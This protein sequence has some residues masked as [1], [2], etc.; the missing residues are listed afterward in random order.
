MKPKLETYQARLK[1]IP[2]QAL[3]DV[4]INNRRMVSNVQK[5][6]LSNG[7]TV[8]TREVHSAP[9]VTV[10][11]W[12]NVGSSQDSLG[13]SGIAHQLEH[14]MFKG[15][16]KRPIQFSKIFNRLGSNSNAFTSY[17]QTAYY[18][19]VYKNQLQALLELE[20]DRMANLLIDSQDLAR[21]KQ[22]VIS[23]LEGYENSPKYRLKRAVMR[24]IFPHHGYGLPTGGTKKDVQNL[25]VEQIRE[26]YEK[27]YHP[28]H[29]ILVIVGDFTT[30]KTLQT[31]KEIFGKIPPSQQS[32]SFPPSPVFQSSS[33]PIIL[34]EPGGRKL[35][36]VIYPLP[37]LHHPDIPA[38]GVMDYILTGGKNS[39]L[40]QTLVSSG[41]VTDLSARVVSLRQGGW[42]DLSVIPAPGQD[43]QTVYSTIESAI[44][45][46][47]QTGI[48]N[49]DIERA[50]RQITA[51]VIFNRQDITSQAMQ[52]ANDQLIANDYE[53]TEKYLEGVSRVN[54]TQVIEITKKYLTKSAVIGF[55][56]PDQNTSNS[57]YQTPGVKTEEFLEQVPLEHLNS[58]EQ[59]VSD[60]EVIKY[61]PS[62]NNS[63][64]PIVGAI[65]P[66]KLKLNNGLK[67]LL[68][69]DR[70]TPTITVA[71]YIQGGKE[72]DQAQKAGLA[73]LVADSLMNG[74]A[75]Q[76]MAAIAETLDS[77]GASLDFTAFREGVRLLGKSLREDLPILLHTVADV[78][79]N[80]NF[81]VKELEISRQKAINKLQLDL[82]DADEV[83]NRKFIQ[84]LYPSN[85]PLHIFP[86]LES[87]QKISREDTLNFRQIYYRPDNMVL[88][89]VGDFELAR[90]KSLLE[91][92]FANWRVDGKAPAVQYPQVARKK[93]GLQINY[94]L[95]GKLQPV[96]YMGNLGVKRQDLRFYSAL[97]LN[98]ILTG[99]T[100]SGRLSSRI[101]DE[102]G[103][104]YRIYSNFQGGK[105]SGTFI[106][107]MQTSSQHT[108]QAIF[109]TREI[110]QDLYQTGVTNGEV[111]AAKHSLI[112]NYNLSLAKLE[113]LTTRILMNEFFGFE[114]MELQTLPS[115]IQ[116]VTRDQV[117]QLARQILNP[118]Q[119]TVVTAGDIKSLS[120]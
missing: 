12:Y 3:S 92:E 64:I 30:S 2:P 88:A 82:Q 59:E 38:L 10:Q 80:S 45:K 120:Q 71:G 109:K 55:F 46:L 60:A 89:I 111:A 9:V 68:L 101:R 44:T 106:I 108:Q 99:D 20:A 110:L 96:T 77:R 5:I 42:Y 93:R 43:L 48:K 119:L 32:P 83:A 40:Y 79:K 112:S 58:G 11:I 34:R 107:E 14:I 114:Q 90:V 19:T 29:A 100:I 67:V 49:K 15:T 1:K 35:L 66:Q 26:H 78:V 50:K 94:P 105:N 8:L 57:S 21:E 36:Q 24:S 63:E 56:V 95:P 84:A 75:R 61:L 102:L 81:P 62:S 47:V 28:N 97:V 103:L 86:T 104:T 76:S 91:M 53:Y 74:T 23:E 22:V 18:H 87:I 70:S 7:L 6:V 25:T 98:E 85:H 17:E 31:V 27:Y 51:S 13:M 73:S 65:I 33:S 118:D 4:D 72:F 54:T 39:H 117:N 69:A 37:N 115:K 116:K 16:K 41:L 52:L 113:E